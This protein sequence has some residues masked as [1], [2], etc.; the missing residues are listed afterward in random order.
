[1]LTYQLGPVTFISHQFHEIL[2][3]SIIK[4]SLKI[5]YLKCHSNLSGANEWTGYKYLCLLSSWC[6]VAA[7]C[8]KLPRKDCLCTH[9]YM[10]SHG[11]SYVCLRPL[12]LIM[13]IVL[14]IFTWGQFGPLLSVSVSTLSLSMWQLITVQAGTIKLGQKIQTHWLRCLLFRG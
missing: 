2:Q 12:F 9:S 6:M 13:L 7:A 14:M 4:I 11:K 5:T 1:M 3:P 8:L 10:G